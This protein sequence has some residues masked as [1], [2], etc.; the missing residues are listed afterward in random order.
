MSTKKTAC[1]LLSDSI[2]AP[3]R[4]EKSEKKVFRRAREDQASSEVWFNAESQARRTSFACGLGHLVAFFH[5][6]FSGWKLADGLTR[7]L[8]EILSSATSGVC[9]RTIFLSIGINDIRW[10]V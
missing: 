4:V 9:V 2:T 5:F 6:V 8:R 1:L 7:Q 3:L 10:V